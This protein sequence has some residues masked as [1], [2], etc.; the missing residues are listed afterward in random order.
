MKA[1]DLLLL[2]CG[3]TPAVAES[4]DEGEAECDIPRL[5]VGDVRA[6]TTPSC[7]YLG[8]SGGGGRIRNETRRLHCSLTVV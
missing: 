6:D 5:I 8:C 4:A 1:N 2:C 3:R 7:P